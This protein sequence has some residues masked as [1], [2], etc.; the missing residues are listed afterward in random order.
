VAIAWVP[1]RPDVTS[2]IVDATFACNIPRWWFSLGSD[3]N[4]AI[5]PVRATD[6]LAEGAEFELADDFV[7]SQQAVRERQRA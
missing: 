1:A 2:A 5:N 7:N 3:T 6:S 4:P